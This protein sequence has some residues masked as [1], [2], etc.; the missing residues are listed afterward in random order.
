MGTLDSV[1][2]QKSLLI[3]QMSWSLFCHLWAIVSFWGAIKMS[4][5]MPL[6][7]SIIY[8]PLAISCFVFKSLNY[9]ALSFIHRETEI[10]LPFHMRI[11]S[12]PSPA[13]F[14]EEDTFS[15]NMHLFLETSILIS[16]VVTFLYIILAPNSKKVVGVAWVSF[17][18]F[19]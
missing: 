2:T 11:Y 1:K 13:P 17:K 6:F 5:F 16:T 14:A 12:F 19:K 9:L 18:T 3:S 15:P 4:L 7:S 10:L 8:F